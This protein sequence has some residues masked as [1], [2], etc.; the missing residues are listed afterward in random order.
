M[1][2]YVSTF[3]DECILDSRFSIREYCDYIATVDDCSIKLFQDLRPGWTLRFE[4]N[5]RLE[6]F[7]DE[8]GIE[9]MRGYIIFVIRPTCSQ[10]MYLLEHEEASD[11]IQTIIGP[12]KQIDTNVFKSDGMVYDFNTMKCDKSSIHAGFIFCLKK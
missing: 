1:H 11:F 10:K 3:I 8:R 5:D 7:A 12:C 6:W 4:W 2:E 9:V